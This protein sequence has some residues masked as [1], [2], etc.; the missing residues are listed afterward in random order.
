MCILE[1]SSQYLAHTLISERTTESH[2]RN[3][4]RFKKG[5]EGGTASET[6]RIFGSPSFLINSA[7]IC[8]IHPVFPPKM[9]TRFIGFASVI[10]V[11]STIFAIESFQL[12]RVTKKRIVMQ[13]TANAFS[14]ATK[15]VVT[16]RASYVSTYAED[17]TYRYP[18]FLKFPVQTQRSN[19]QSAKK[20]KKKGNALFSICP[21]HLTISL[22]KYQSNFLRVGST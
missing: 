15:K 20:C 7:I 18:S 10:V 4:G 8:P 2:I 5:K 11:S 9:R 14:F 13:K 1:V 21:S 17:R 16:L 19:K 22:Q 6:P 12:W 3:H